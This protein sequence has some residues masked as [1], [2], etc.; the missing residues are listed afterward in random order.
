MGIAHVI[1]SK[2]IHSLRCE[3]HSW[4]LITLSNLSSLLIVRDRSCSSQPVRGWPYHTNDV[5]DSFDSYGK[6][7][8]WLLDSSEG[9]KWT[10]LLIRNT[11]FEIWSLQQPRGLA[12]QRRVQIISDEIKFLHYRRL[13]SLKDGMDDERNLRR[14]N[15]DCCNLPA[16]AYIT[17]H[18]E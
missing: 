4:R 5:L 18:L 11:E 9:N 13:G 12:S 15:D 10:I 16:C 3:M 6:Y 7:S 2:D 14:W 8:K 17:I 1:H